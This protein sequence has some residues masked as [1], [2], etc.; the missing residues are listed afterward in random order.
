MSVNVTLQDGG[1]IQVQVS[2]RQPTQVNLGRISR[3]LQGVPGPQAPFDAEIFRNSAT[4]P[5]Q[6][7]GGSIVVSPYA[8]TPPTGAFTGE[9]V[10]TTPDGMHL[11]IARALVDP[12]VDT[13]TI[14]NPSWGPWTLAG[15][16]GPKG[17]KGDA[18]QLF[19][20]YSADN[21][22][23]SDTVVTNTKWVRFA[24]ELT[25]P[26]NNSNKWSA[27][28]RY[29]GTD[30]I[31]GINGTNGFTP[32][33]QF[34]ANG[35]TG[36]NTTPT[37]TRPFIRFQTGTT[38][39]TAG[40]RYFGED[41]ED[42][43]DGFTPVPQFSAN[44]TSGWS[45][46][47]TPASDK[48]IRFQTGPTAFTAGVKF[49][50]EDGDNGNPGDHVFI[51]YSADNMA[52]QNTP[53]N[54]TKYVRFAEASARPLDDSSDWSDGIE[55]P[56]G[57]PGELSGTLPPDRIEQD[58]AT[59]GQALVW[60]GDNSEWT[61]GDVASDGEPGINEI[62]ITNDRNITA[63]SWINVISQTAT[64]ASNTAV[65]QGERFLSYGAGLN[66][67]QDFD[68][69]A[70]TY[71]VECDLWVGSVA[72]QR[73]MPMVRLTD[74]TDEL[75]RSTVAYV[76]SPATAYRLFPV[77]MMVTFATDQTGLEIEVGSG[78]DE[79]DETSFNANVTT[80]SGS[81]FNI[82]GSISRRTRFRFHRMVAGSLS[83]GGASI[84][85]YDEG[86]ALAT[87]MARLNIIG[88]RVTARN[89]ASNAAHK[90]MDFTLT[91]RDI[92]ANTVIAK[93]NHDRLEDAGAYVATYGDFSNAGD[94]QY[95]AHYGLQL[96]PNTAGFNSFDYAT[97]YPTGDDTGTQELRISVPHGTDLETVRV[98]R[99][100][101]GGG[102]STY[103]GAG[104][105]GKVAQANAHEGVEYFEWQGSGT[106]TLRLGIAANDTW[107]IQTR[108]LT[109]V[110][111]LD[112]EKL[113]QVGATAG[114]AL[115][116]DGDNDEWAPGDVE[117]DVDISGD[118][119]IEDL[120]HLTRDLHIIAPHQDW[121]EAA[122]G[123]ADLYG[124]INSSGDTPPTGITLTDADF[125]GNGP[126]ITSGSTPHVFYAFYIRLPIATD[127]SNFRV[128]MEYS[129]ARGD[130]AWH[131]VTGPSPSTYQYYFVGQ[132][133]NYTNTRVHVQKLPDALAKTQ[134]GGELIED[135]ATPAASARELALEN[136]SRLDS[137]EDIEEVI[138][139][140]A[141]VTLKQNVAG[142]Q[143]GSS[144]DTADETE[145]DNFEFG[146]LTFAG[147][148]TNRI[149][150][151]STPAGVSVN[152]VRL[153]WDGTIYP[154]TATSTHWESYRPTAGAKSDREYYFVAADSDNSP[155]VFSA[156]SSKELDMQI[157]S[158]THRFSV[159]LEATTLKAWQSATATEAP[160]GTAQEETAYIQGGLIPIEFARL[161]GT[162]HLHF[163]VPDS[164]AIDL[165]SINGANA[166]E[167]FT[168]DEGNTGVRRYHSAELSNAGR[169]DLLVRVIRHVT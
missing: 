126:D 167:N 51:Q 104:N 38:T 85:L 125:A 166:F 46:T 141:N 63:R 139:A 74:G 23:W 80:Q 105:W 8:L 88:Q 44:G 40:V 71:L 149:F 55:L 43:N 73:P 87:A 65:V 129:S 109:E 30:G 99:T 112:P 122:D 70:G 89:N 107:R 147:T 33:P 156:G 76:R 150:G 121:E 10:P 37:A 64:E 137:I 145:L 135:A 131:R 75:A 157:A 124:V 24:A 58:G 28:V 45:A 127:T 79:T 92:G 3:G 61:P 123:D 72:N 26:G 86:T 29:V 148:D 100:T 103:G 113:A 120:L 6:A 114:Q 56:T 60:D 69:K 50:A 159:T 48:W 146:D 95:F 59:D 2:Q 118:A 34:S 78:P 15:A 54:G 11:Y 119:A 163:E 96:A 138:G 101:N 41:G 57:P 82:G 154:S 36:W 97:A 117:A 5:A 83:A 106:S 42:G 47:P 140:F 116:W 144:T 14:T 160:P 133:G 19:I 164:Y 13:G 22:V 130:N 94:D 84:F 18:E 158:I 161:T 128:Y 132:A 142:W 62:I 27:G 16:R 110:F 20:Q 39:Y 91:D 136:K 4:T 155:T 162:R 7:T 168:A 115:L 111:S 165:I 90:E 108:S 153:N 81:S 77:V 25:K 31:N 53:P 52:W 1:G 66:V 169:I 102:V 93:R 35:T 152:R 134:Y 21:S 32:V 49:V 9:S 12:A 151:I 98:T 67:D 68:L 143:F 17:D